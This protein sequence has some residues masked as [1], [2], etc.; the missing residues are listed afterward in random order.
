MSEEIVHICKDC[1]WLWIPDSWGTYSMR[2][3]ASPIVTISVVT[4][5]DVYYRWCADR[6]KG[7]KLCPDYSP[8]IWK[9]IKDFF[10]RL[11]R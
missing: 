2:C 10:G 6:R 9:R 11:F 3:K 1:K 8:S 5:K 7:E 4:G